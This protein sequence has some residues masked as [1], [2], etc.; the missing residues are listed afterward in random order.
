MKK[1]WNEYLKAPITI[2]V[3][4]HLVGFGFFLGASAAARFIGATVVIGYAP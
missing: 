2:I 1:F 4:S 3:I